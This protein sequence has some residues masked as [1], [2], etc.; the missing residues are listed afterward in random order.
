MPITRSAEWHQAPSKCCGYWSSTIIS[1]ATATGTS[2]AASVVIRC[3]VQSSIVPTMNAVSPP[4]TTHAPKAKLTCATDVDEYANL[5]LSCDDN[6][7]RKDQPY[8]DPGH[9]ASQRH[10]LRLPTRAQAAKPQSAGK[11][12]NE[13]DG[14]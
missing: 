5:L 11:D 6:A 10:A 4:A 9:R 3:L 14:D 1:A 8:R 12:A 13:P 2:I 7:C